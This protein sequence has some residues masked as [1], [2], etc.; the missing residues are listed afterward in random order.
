[1]YVSFNISIWD[2]NLSVADRNKL[3]RIVRTA[4]GWQQ[5]SLD[6]LYHTGVLKT[7]VLLLLSE[8]VLF[9]LM[10]L[11]RKK[12]VYGIICM[13]VGIIT[14]IFIMDWLWIDLVNQR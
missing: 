14:N 1:M 8:N 4:V 12:S 9:I 7:P 5:T 11:G 2:G 10:L 3:D 13:N 6:N